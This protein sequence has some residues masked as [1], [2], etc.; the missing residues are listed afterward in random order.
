MERNSKA[1][2]PDLKTQATSLKIDAFKE[3]AEKN[4]QV[5]VSLPEFEGQA[6]ARHTEK[7]LLVP[8]SNLGKVYET[9]TECPFELPAFRFWPSNF[10]TFA[11]WVSF[12]TQFAHSYAVKL[13][14][15]AA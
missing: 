5:I 8:I 14:T 11:D 9:Y 13:E 7:V 10:V 15:V 3:F 6:K 4:L 1:E 2:N 12:Y